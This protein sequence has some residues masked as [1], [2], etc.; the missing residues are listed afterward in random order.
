M[1]KSFNEQQKQ[2]VIEGSTF[3]EYPPTT[4][5]GIKSSMALLK[6]K[7]NLNESTGYNSMEG[8]YKLSTSYNIGSQPL[9]EGSTFAE[10]PPTTSQG[11]KSSMVP[12]ADK[13]NLSTSTRYNSKE[14]T[15][16]SPNN[17]VGI[18]Y[19]PNSNNTLSQIPTTVSINTTQPI[20]NP[21]INPNLPLGTIKQTYT[22]TTTTTNISGLNQFGT[23]IVQ[24]LPGATF[25]T[26]P[27]TTSVNGIQ[28]SAIPSNNPA[29]K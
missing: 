28:S 26:Y 27:M 21:I 14:G 12:T 16:N 8:E 17:N 2:G 7:Q 1:D 29:P 6:D 5:Q 10:Y 23:P 4:S 19:P 22:V 15:Y 20:I 13:T 24:P 9:K 18:N 11:I 3:A 25:S